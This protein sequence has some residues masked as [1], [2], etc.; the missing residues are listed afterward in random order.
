MKKIVM[1][2]AFLIGAAVSITLAG[3]EK[4]GDIQT[5]AVTDVYVAAKT[6]MY[7]S[8]EDLEESSTVIVRGT[9]IYE[10]E[11][12]ID[13][14][15]EDGGIVA[16][17]TLSDIEIK[18]IYKDDSGQNLK[19]SNQ[20]TII[21]NTAIDETEHIRYHIAGY[22]MMELYKEYILFLKYSK[23]DQWFI[24]LGV[25]FGKFP[26]DERE[27]LIYEEIDEDTI[28]ERIA[29]EVREKYS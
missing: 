24:P 18:E 6:D 7:D 25:T 3:C 20:I 28:E 29:D 23:E 21:E 15:K 5:H 1:Q 10:G 4:K 14:H 12:Q 19:V 2:K 13:R 9:K 22:N 11:P 27:E 16:T 8:V 17:Y 26:L